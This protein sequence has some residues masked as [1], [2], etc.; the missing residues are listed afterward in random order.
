MKD[1]FSVLKDVFGNWKYLIL[2]VF[3]SLIFYFINVLIANF[4]SIKSYFSMSLFLGMKFFLVLSLG[5]RETILP[6]SFAS[7]IVIGIFLGML[8]SLITYKTIMIKGVSGKIGIFGV[9]GIFLGI[10]APGC[11]ACGIG[12]LSALGLGSAV[13]TFLP[14]KGLEISLLAI[15]ILGFSIVKISKDIKKGIVCRIN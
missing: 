2:A 5:F 7:M 3:I 1:S 4:S 13:L 6:S 12:L 9:S 15:G 14:L 10:L 11:A 8:S